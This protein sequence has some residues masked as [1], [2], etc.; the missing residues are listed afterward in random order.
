MIDPG[1]PT[2]HLEHA[3]E[4]LDQAHREHLKGLLTAAGP[5]AMG[6]VAFLAVRKQRREVRAELAARAE[7]ID[8]GCE[9]VPPSEEEIHNPAHGHR[10]AA[11][12]R[13][14]EELPGWAH[15]AEIDGRAVVVENKTGRLIC[16]ITNPI[17]LAT[18][19]VARWADV[20]RPTVAPDG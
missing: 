1:V 16:T 12:R 5:L 15:L 14:A 3:A 19:D 6:L 2:E 9:E 10:E 11:L 13:I 8:A 7:A 18:G 20:L 4:Q 17:G